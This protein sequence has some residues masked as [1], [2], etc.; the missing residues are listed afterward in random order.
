[1]RI[2]HETDDFR[3][4]E[5]VIAKDTS[6]QN[7]TMMLCEELGPES[8]RWEPSYGIKRIEDR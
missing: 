8:G 4:Y 7:I 3:K 6:G 5:P 1:M 2:I